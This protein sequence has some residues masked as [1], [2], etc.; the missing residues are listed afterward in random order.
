MSTNRKNYVDIEVD[1]QNCKYTVNGAP[2]EFEDEECTEF[3][4]EASRKNNWLRFTATKSSEHSYVVAIVGEVDNELGTDSDSKSGRKIPAV[5][6]TSG[7]PAE[8]KIRDS[9]YKDP[10]PITLL[11]MIR[12]GD[13]YQPKENCPAKAMMLTVGGP[14]MKVDR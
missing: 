5:V 1:C 10:F 14:K 11:C 2:C 9:E 4:V 7:S 13:Y 12:D 3:N 8:L 6:F